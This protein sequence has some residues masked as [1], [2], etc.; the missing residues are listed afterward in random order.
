METAHKLYRQ[1]LTFDKLQEMVADIENDADRYVKLA[2]EA[3]AELQYRCETEDTHEYDFVVNS[4]CMNC[5]L[6]YLGDITDTLEQ[7]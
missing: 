7:G 5:G 4:E 3:R 6:E 2:K 1:T